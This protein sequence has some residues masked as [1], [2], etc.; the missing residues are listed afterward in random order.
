[1]VLFKIILIIRFEYTVIY[2]FVFMLD[3]FVYL[4]HCFISFHDEQ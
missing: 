1:M 3:L 4:M 2:V